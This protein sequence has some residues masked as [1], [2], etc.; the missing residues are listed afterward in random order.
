MRK[1]YREAIE[2]SKS[3]ALNKPEYKRILRALCLAWYELKNVSGSDGDYTEVL[4][5]D[6]T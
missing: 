6:S 1:E 5:V 2:D 4:K 3:R